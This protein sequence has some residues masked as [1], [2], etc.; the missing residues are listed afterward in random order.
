MNQMFESL[1]RLMDIM[2]GETNTA[3]VAQFEGEPFQPNAT[4]ALGRT[5]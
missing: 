5:S 3:G 1:P 4:S 2:Y